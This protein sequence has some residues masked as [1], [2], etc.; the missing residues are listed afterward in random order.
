MFMCLT[1]TILK[2]IQTSFFPSWLNIFFFQLWIF[3]CKTKPNR[4]TTN[5]HYK[6]KQTKKKTWFYQCTVRSFLVMLC[7]KHFSMSLFSIIHGLCVIEFSWMG[8]NVS[9]GKQQETLSIPASSSC[10][11]ISYA[12]SNDLLIFFS[13]F[14]YR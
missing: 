2:T 6:N 7:G 3:Q 13:S 1:A 4:K 14:P 11:Q 9:L 8:E 12:Y 10:V 5:I